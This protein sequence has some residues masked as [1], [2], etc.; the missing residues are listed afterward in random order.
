M[1]D[2]ALERWET[3]ITS[4]GRDLGCSFCKEYFN[5]YD[6]ECSDECPLLMYTKKT[7]DDDNSPYDIWNNTPMDSKK[8]RE[9]SINIWMLIRFISL[10]EGVD[11]F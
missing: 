11:T 3:K 5:D 7:C 1:Y 2:L 4:E 10:S 8:E 6:E 9:A